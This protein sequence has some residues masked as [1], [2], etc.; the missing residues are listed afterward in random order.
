MDL[1]SES[2]W[3]KPLGHGFGLNEG[4]IDFLGRRTKDAV[5]ADGMGGHAFGLRFSGFVFFR[6]RIDERGRAGWTPK[7]GLSSSAAN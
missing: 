3:R 5:K 1:S 7:V 6:Q 4:A 2:V